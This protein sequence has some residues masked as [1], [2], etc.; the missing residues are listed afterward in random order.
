MR[1]STTS[2]IDLSFYRGL[3][4]TEWRVS[5]S[6]SL[7]DQNYVCF[8]VDNRSRASARLEMRAHANRGWYTR[9]LA[10]DALYRH[11]STSSLEATA[12]P[13]DTEQALS[14]A[15]S[16]DTFFFGV[17]EA[18]MCRKRTGLEGRRLVYWWSEEITELHRQSLTLRRRY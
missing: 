16:L 3:D 18:S 4:L 17:C 15:E 9:K 10:S 5:E 12:G 13:V 8:S 1:G 2:I 14:S 7:S 6:E 11:H